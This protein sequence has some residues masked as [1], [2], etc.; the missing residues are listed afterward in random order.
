LIE[1]PK[2]ELWALC[3][4]VKDLKD[5]TGKTLILKTLARLKEAPLKGIA[6]FLGIL[7]G[8]EAAKKGYTKIIHA[9]MRSNNASVKASDKTSGEV[10][11]E[12]VLYGKKL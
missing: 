9:L 7:T 2:G 11:S 6:Y 12:Y 4:A 3:F 5:P 10:I 8:A 1:N